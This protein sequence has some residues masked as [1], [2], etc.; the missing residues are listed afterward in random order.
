VR[1]NGTT[2]LAIVQSASHYGLNAHAHTV[3]AELLAAVPLPA[4]LHWSFA[5]F[6][7]LEKWNSHSAVIIDPANGRRPVG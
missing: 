3:E 4:I 7:V 1:C 5:H 2:V 6:V